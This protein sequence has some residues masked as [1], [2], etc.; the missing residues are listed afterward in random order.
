[1]LQQGVSDSPLP[2]GNLQQSRIAANSFICRYFSK[3]L[4][5]LES[6]SA[7][8]GSLNIQSKQ[9][10]AASHRRHF[11]DIYFFMKIVVT[12][13]LVPWVSNFMAIFKVF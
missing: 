10:A 5:I 11:D 3:F 4:S 12:G 7:F 2:A 1:M 8:E 13:A 9:A 6:S